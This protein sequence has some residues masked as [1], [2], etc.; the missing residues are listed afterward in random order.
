M[1][2]STGVDQ[3][4]GTADGK[5]DEAAN[6]PEGD[7]SNKGDAKSWKK[8]Y[9][10]AAA[11]NTKKTNDQQRKHDS[12][13]ADNRRSRSTSPANK[14][15][16][17]TTSKVFFQGPTRQRQGAG[18]PPLEVTSGEA[19]ETQPLAEGNGSDCNHGTH[20]GRIQE[21]V[22]GQEVMQPLHRI[23][24]TA[25]CS[26]LGYSSATVG[27][28]IQSPQ[29]TEGTLNGLISDMDRMEESDRFFEINCVDDYQKFFLSVPA[30]DTSVVNLSSMVLS[31]HH[32]LLLSKGLKFCPTPDE[33]NMAELRTHLDKFHRK[34]RFRALF[35][36]D[37]E[38]KLPPKPVGRPKKRTG[39]VLE[40]GTQGN[41]LCQ[42]HSHSLTNTN[43]VSEPRIGDGTN[44][45][46]TGRRGR[47]HRPVA[48]S[49]GPFEHTDFKLPS[50][51]D[52]PN[53]PSAVES[54][55]FQ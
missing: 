50:T 4:D 29:C 42:P 46:A 3:R 24:P 33:V 27:Q 10:K 40:S 17:A 20:A 51:A 39:D 21:A 49:S 23:Q 19:T 9:A 34:L 6:K 47:A 53:A 54:R 28:D 2:A 14:S 11:T 12:T 22:K 26:L 8:S 43:D 55:I 41:C 37:D 35:H 18:S 16:R 48:E 30:V 5:K 13:K 15:P 7:E 36:K 38:S 52:P 32:I 44:D 45:C 1:P 25:Q 31:E